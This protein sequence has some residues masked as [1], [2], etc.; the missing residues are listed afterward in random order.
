VQDHDPSFTKWA[1]RSVTS[2]GMAEARTAPWRIV[3]GARVATRPRGIGPRHRSKRGTDSWNR[4]RRR[5]WHRILEDRLPAPFQPPPS[6]PLQRPV[7]RRSAFHRTGSTNAL[8]GGQRRSPMRTSSRERILPN[9]PR[10]CPMMFQDGT[11][12][13]SH[14]SAPPISQASWLA[15]RTPCSGFACYLVDEFGVHGGPACERP[16][17]TQSRLIL[18]Q[19]WIEAGSP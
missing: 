18:S 15:E 19:E 17:D 13:A 16:E 10:P 5:H 3:G 9:R 1:S 11:R 4:I 7:S 12:L 6:K 2:G 8:P 14:S